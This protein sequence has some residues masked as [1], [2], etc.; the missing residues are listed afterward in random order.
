MVC[1]ITNDQDDYAHKVADALR[2]QG[3]RV[4]TD[5]SANKINY[6]VREHSLQKVPFIIAVGPRDVENQSVAVRELGK[7]GQEILALS[8]AILKLKELAAVPA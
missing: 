5:L 7:D 2:A 3:M 1:T 8:D 4:E 6:K